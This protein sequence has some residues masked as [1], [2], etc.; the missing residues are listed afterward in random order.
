MNVVQ[1]LPALALA[2]LLVESALATGNGPTV[3]AGLVADD[4]SANRQDQ[5]Q[6]QQQQSMSQPQ[7]EMKLCP[8]M[9]RHIF[10]GYVP[11]GELWGDGGG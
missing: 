2:A 4:V 10:D 5:D 8:R 11:K 7:S 9:F 3:A 6:Q 1:V